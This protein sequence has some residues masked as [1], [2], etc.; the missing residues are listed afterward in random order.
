MPAARGAE[1]FGRLAR[2]LRAIGDKE[3]KRELYRGLNRA[4]KPAKDKV[5]PSAQ[6]ELPKR[7][8]LNDF[9]AGSTR[10]S[11]RTRSGRR[12]PSV[13]IVARGPHD[14][15]ALD[16]GRVRHPVFGNRNAWRT[17]QI[18]PGWFSEP[19][20]QMAPQMRQEM[21]QVLRDVDRDLR[22]LYG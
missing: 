17:Q 16:R 8:G 3:L 13:R 12:N 7:G 15:Y 19:I 2:S 11:V 21:D 14:V 22:R 6:S 1:D 18:N 5:K 4:A 10:A 20:A 9:I